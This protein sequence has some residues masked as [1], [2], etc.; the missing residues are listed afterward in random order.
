MS[1]FSIPVLTLTVQAA[2]ALSANRFVTGAGAV[3]AAGAQCA[4][5]TR[6]RAAAAGDLVPVDVLGT[7]QI[8]TG[9]AVSANGAVE[10]DNQGRAVALSSG[11]KLA[12]LAPGEPPAT[13]AGQF[14]EFVLIPG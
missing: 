9:G 8:E 14:R 6:T 12:R 2:A 13:A 10:T 7:T 4:G 11:A 5:V 1:S 3:P